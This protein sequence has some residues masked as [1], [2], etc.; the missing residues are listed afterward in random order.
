LLEGGLLLWGA[1]MCAPPS[2]HGTLGPNT[3]TMPTWG[4]GP[5]LRGPAPAQQDVPRTPT[6]RRGKLATVGRATTEHACHGCCCC[7]H[8]CV[9]CAWCPHSIASHRGTIRVTRCAPLHT[10]PPFPDTTGDGGSGQARQWSAGGPLATGPAAG[11]GPHGQAAA[12]GA[13]RGRD[14]G[15]TPGASAVEAGGTRREGVGVGV[16][17]WTA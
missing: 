15:G 2:P 7:G 17:M 12:V 9:T 14:Q 11:S 4:E 1:A 6:L 3:F 5:L 8:V 10:P 13:V 16:H